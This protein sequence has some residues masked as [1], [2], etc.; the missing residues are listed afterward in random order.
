MNLTRFPALCRAIPQALACTLLLSQAPLVSAAWNTNLLVNPGADATAGGDGNFVANLPG[1]NVT[2]ELTAIDY[3]LGCPGGYP[4]LTDPGPSDPGANHFGGGYGT[5]SIGRQTIDLGFAG[6]SINGAGAYY[7]LSG[8]LGG[9]ATQEDH[10]TLDVNFLNASNQIVGSK[11]IGP[12]TPT[13]R[14]GVTAMLLREAN[15]W[16]PAGATSAEVVLS[17]IRT[18]GSSNDGY[19]DSLSFSLKQANT[20]LSAPNA[21][22]VG[23]TFTTTVVALSPF[24]SAEESEEL[25]AFGFD[26]DFDPTLLRLTNVSMPAGFDDDSSFFEDTDV[27]GSSFPGLPVSGDEDFT[28]VTLTFE[29]LA[30][31]QAFIQVSS[32]AAGNFNEGLILAQ[33]ASI[34]VFGRTSVALAPV[35]EPSTLALAALGLAALGIRRRRIA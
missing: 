21:A 20:M 10:V 34:D 32:D 33:G 6:S 4:C 17:A 1:W 9:Y 16:V 23:S 27:A 11:T 35:P 19:A 5:P 25:L 22:S 31:G 14:G 3:S 30:E 13:D 29:V 12:V 28:L 24:A 7:A 2:G 26:L 18:G 8:W 15:G